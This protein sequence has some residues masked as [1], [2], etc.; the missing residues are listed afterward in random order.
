MFQNSES[1]EKKISSRVT[2]LVSNRP[3]NQNERYND[4]VGQKTQ[5][6]GMTSNKGVKYRRDNKKN[7]R[8]K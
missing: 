4:G 5:R 7:A 6:K 8:S 3:Q 2:Q 1:I